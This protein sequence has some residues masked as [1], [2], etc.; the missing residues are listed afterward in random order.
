MTAVKDQTIGDYLR[1]LASTA[2]VPGGGSAAA[3]AAAMGAAL[4]SMVAKLSAK[5]AKGNEDRVLLEGLVPEL[6][7][8]STRL[9]QLSQDDVDAYRAV[10]DTRKSGAQGDALARAYERAAEVP[11][12][13][14]TAAARGLALVPEVSKRAWE[15]T[16]SDL[17]V[18][19]ELLE[20]GFAGALGNV[21]IN[22]PE[23]RGEAAARIERAYLELRTLKAQ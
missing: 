22:L 10:I 2:A 21:A 20:T 13:S 14:A 18:G 5:K 23:L 1:A 12:A 7:Q 9:L 15:M 8:L 3:L 16:A 11:L 19:S 17:A 6:D 4:V